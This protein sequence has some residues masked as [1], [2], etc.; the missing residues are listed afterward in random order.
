[1]EAVVLWMVLMDR[2]ELH[3]HLVLWWHLG[4]VDPDRGFFLVGVFLNGSEPMN[5]AAGFL[6]AIR[7]TSRIYIRY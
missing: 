5:P 1:M 4:I 6:L 7:T 3:G 2:V